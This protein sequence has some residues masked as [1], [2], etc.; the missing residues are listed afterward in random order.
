MAAYGGHNDELGIQ[1]FVSIR[2]GQSYPP[3]VTDLR[4]RYDQTLADL[5]QAVCRALDIPADKLQLFRY[6]KELP[7]TM[8][9]KSIMEM[10][11]HTG[12][13]LQGWDLSEEPDYWPPV[14]AGPDGLLQVVS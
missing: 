3:R 6:G 12:F 9:S 8:D 1:I 14:K 5:R 13:G 2:R 10:D 11:I 4:L 7:A